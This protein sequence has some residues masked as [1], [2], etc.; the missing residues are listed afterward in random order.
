MVPRILYITCMVTGRRVGL[1]TLFAG[2]DRWSSC[3]LMLTVTLETEPTIA[4]VLVFLVLR[5]RVILMMCVGVTPMSSGCPAREC[6]VWT[7]L[8][9]F[10]G[11][12]FTV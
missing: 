3:A 7:I 11:A 5:V 1:S 10:L 4:R 2:C 6:M 9:V 12:E 8:V